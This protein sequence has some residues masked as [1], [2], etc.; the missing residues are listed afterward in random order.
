MITRLWAP[1]PFEPYFPKVGAAP[2]FSPP[3]MGRKRDQA[4]LNSLD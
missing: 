4:D 3:P 2:T 1:T